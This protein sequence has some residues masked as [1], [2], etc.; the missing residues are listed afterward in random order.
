MAKKKGKNGL[1]KCKYNGLSANLLTKMVKF[2][3]LYSREIAVITTKSAFVNYNAVASN[4][5]A[6]EIESSITYTSTLHPM[7]TSLTGTNNEI[8]YAKSK[9]KILGFCR[10]LRNS[11]CH[12]LLKET[13]YRLMIEDK[14]NGRKTCM[15]IIETTK[16]AK[17]IDALVSN[18]ENDKNPNRV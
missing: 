13:N 4:V 3:Y 14:N 7:P 9:N 8:H 17:F 6:N 16:V 2:C 1:P 18:Y 11:M 15:G 5:F 10:H 12:G